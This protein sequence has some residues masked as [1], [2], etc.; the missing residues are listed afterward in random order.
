VKR[1]L[2]LA[3]IAVACDKGEHRDAR[4]KFN[5]GV[6]ALA[7][8][9]YE[10]AEKALL[11]ARSSA[12]VDPELRFR[13]A[14]DL[15]MAYAAHADQ[16]KTGKDADLD[17]ALELEQ[18][19]LNWFSD[20]ARQNKT[21]AD[22]QANLAI[23]RA[24]T[25]AL[26]DELARGQGKLEARLDAVIK[27][28]RGVLDQAREAWIS[29][30]QAG[31]TDPLAQ[32]APL[33]KLAD[34]ERGVVAEAGVISDLASDEIDSIGKKP[35]DKRDQQEAARVVQL[36][37]L[38][39]YMLDSRTKISEARRKLQDL[40]AE[41]AVAKAE[42][43]LVALKRA[44]EQLL[45]PI[46]VLRAVAGDE[47]Q[48]AQETHAVAQVRNQDFQIS[49]SGTGS[50]SGSTE[51]KPLIPAWL[52]PP[53]LGDRQTGLHD[54]VEEVKQRLAATVDSVDKPM[55]TGSAAEPPKLTAE[56]AK[57]IEQLRLALPF[58]TEAS[59]DMTQAHDALVAQK[60][61]EATKHERD[62]L[63]A[64]AKAIEYFADLKQTVDLAYATQQQ[65]VQLFSPEAAKLPAAERAQDA[66]EALASN[67]ARMGRIK[68]LISDEQAVL[69]AKLEEADAKAKA[70][71][72]P[73]QP[74]QPPAQ[75]PD[76][77]QIEAAKQQLQQQQQMLNGAEALRG[78][79]EKALATLQTAVKANKDALT[80]AKA[81]EAKLDEL[82]KLFFSVIEHLQEL[83]REQNETKDQ[84]SQ[85]NSEDD[86]TRGPKLPGL[87]T[88]ENEH[89]D[90][91][92]AITDALA[93]Q[94]DAGAKGQ[95]EQQEQAKKMSAAADEVRQASGDMTDAK[96]GLDKATTAKQSVSLDATVKSEGKAIEH[97]ENALKLLQPPP[98]K[99]DQ[100]QKQDQKKQDQQQKQDQQKK[101]QQQQ[102]QQ[103]GAGQR[104]RDE[105]AKRQRDKQQR[106]GGSDPVD[107]DW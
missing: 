32:Q 40:A 14:Y 30:K 12:G 18:Q 29:I 107:K 88:K 71:P 105:D 68:D 21:D 90:M 11:E 78:D 17:K 6:D 20:A 67:V 22:T 102:Q 101:D 97:L 53:A 52:E 48:L 84:T 46:Q 7:A 106:E 104:A 65:L 45:D 37:N 74:G 5:A 50:G 75:A 96:T 62:A 57:M 87:A 85:A 81:A 98:K 103:G 41:D 77:K 55:G 34:E 51:A 60:L 23:V 13:A 94:A 64:L 31:G 61:D 49:G 25:Q 66:T 83:L 54:R 10:D 16:M 36:K 42:T 80:P 58:V 92:K 63:V 100:D 3:L 4:E 19:A 56:Q 73:A 9:K 99:N 69:A 26:T 15:G 1:V 89:V 70:P 93:K 35:A 76:P 33:T 59:T 72:P 27:E 95:G 44:R 38:D 47:V 43:A 86:F 2:L 79:A 39:I 82:R 91:A 8:G 24:R 28:Q